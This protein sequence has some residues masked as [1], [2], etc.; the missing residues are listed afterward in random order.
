MNIAGK[1]YTAEAQA[2]KGDLGKLFAAS[3]SLGKVR[4]ELIEK[5]Q[6]FWATLRTF[7][8]Q[9]GLSQLLMNFLAWLRLPLALVW[10]QQQDHRRKVDQESAARL[11]W[12]L[13]H[14]S[15]TVDEV[16][17]MTGRQFEEFLARLFSRMSY[18]DI[19]LTPTTNDQGGDLLCLTPSGARAVIQAKRWKGSVGNRAVQELLGAMLNYGRTEGMV[20]TNSTFTKAARELAMKDS[21]VAIRDGQWLTEQIT[22]FLPPEIP[23]FNWEEYNRVVKDWQPF[24][25]GR[26]R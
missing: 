21:R 19:T 3:N 11:K 2:A 14:E 26:T 1:E 6:A 18:R 8:K 25:S 17:R 22:Q 5:Q 10:Q 24:R 13:F 12:R 9:T 4:H 23:E 20:V 7:Q 16:S 15:K